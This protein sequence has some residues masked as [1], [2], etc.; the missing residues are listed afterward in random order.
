[1]TDVNRSYLSTQKYGAHNFGSWRW[2][3][4]SLGGTAQCLF[5]EQIR[6]A[7][8]RWGLQQHLWSQVSV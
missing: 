4:Q 6:C 8:Q 1:M 2:I 5:V 7:H 3:G